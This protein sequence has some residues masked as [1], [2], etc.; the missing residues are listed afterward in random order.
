MRPGSFQPALVKFSNILVLGLPI[1][2]Y[3]YIQI[4]H[5]LTSFYFIKN[6]ENLRDH[7]LKTILKI[8]VSIIHCLSYI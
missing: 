6:Q 4:I 8:N 7:N 3:H 2:P 1:N 5:I